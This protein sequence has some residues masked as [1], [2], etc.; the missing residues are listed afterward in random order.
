MNLFAR[1][2]YAFIKVGGGDD[3][4]NVS[5]D[6][7]GFAAGIGGEYMFNAQSGLRLEYTYYDLNF[8][9]ADD[10]DFEDDDSAGGDV[11][12]LSYVRKF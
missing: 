2:G 5:L 11:F 7:D 12:S 4:V 9:I 1:A 8:D 6:A 10:L 3:G